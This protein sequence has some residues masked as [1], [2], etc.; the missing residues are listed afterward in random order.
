MDIFW[1]INYRIFHYKFLT[2]RIFKKIIRPKKGEIE[3][4]QKLIENLAKK[5]P[6]SLGKKGLSKILFNFGGEALEQSV[7]QSIKAS[8]GVIPILGALIGVLLDVF[9]L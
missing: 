5:S 2:I 8:I 9:L 1:F 6:A 7:K 4:S 3:A